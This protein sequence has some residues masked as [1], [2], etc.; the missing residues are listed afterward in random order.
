MG[1]VSG[2]LGT[3]GG[4][5][6]TGISAPQ[7]AQIDRPTT[8]AQADNAY[9]GTQ[10]SLEQQQNLLAALQQQNGIQN[11]NNVFSQLQGVANGTGANPAQAQLAQ[12]TGANTANQAA[13]MAGQRGSGA[14]AGLLARQAAMQGANNQQNAIGQ[15]ATL[16]ANQSLNALNQMNGVASQQVSNQIG[17][18]GANTAA[19]QAQ[20]GQILGSIGNQNNAAVGNQSNINN[21]NASLASST[22]KGQQDLMGNLT[23]SAGAAVGLAEG[24][25]IPP[26]PQRYAE[27]T[28][29]IQPIPQPAPIP[30]PLPFDAPVAAPAVAA[31]SVAKG[32]RSVIGQLFNPPPQGEL[33][34]AGKTGAAMGKGI[35]AVLNSVFGPS[36]SDPRYTN[37][38]T[39]RR[40]LDAS[41]SLS[42]AAKN[43]GVYQE[44][45]YAPQELDASNA[46]ANAFGPSRVMGA[47]GG[48]VPA[49]VSPG[50]QYI[51]P[52]E[53]KD[54]V[55]GKK[56]PLSA[57]ERIPGKPKF[58]GNDY[59]N[60]TV[61]KTLETGG[62]VIP[63][64]I[65]QAKNPHW[66]AKKFV[67]AHMAQKGAM[68]KKPKA[69]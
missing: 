11:Q 28:P 61:K 23:G 37:E 47:E 26:V 2:L 20:Q 9:A 31:P 64:E 22:M 35:G 44:G 5:N 66:A 48:K 53:I 15:A 68:P 17:A 42:Q 69:K 63:N 7:S 38:E 62:L 32:P 43:A 57:G 58:P 46:G 14:N 59:R 6:G 8:I 54:V 45:A 30:Q 3:A 33:S 21:A 1:F 40:Y 4:V 12:A 18:T 13:L 19:Q 67:E 16:Q 60:D 27:G 41:Q 52:S 51:P 34:G 24:G 25:V 56:D 36:D 10:A 65:M 29:N 55:S 50:E 39:Q 49:L